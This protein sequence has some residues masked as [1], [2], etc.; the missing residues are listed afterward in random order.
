MLIIKKTNSTPSVKL[1]IEECI[2][3]IK[4]LSFSNDV[5]SFYTPIIEWVEKEFPKLECELKC[6]FN[7]SVF[8]SVTYKYILN[9]MT[10]IL[11]Y[12]QEGKNIK[13]VWYYDVDD[14]D[15][16][17]SAE[18]IAELFNIPFELIKND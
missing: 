1:S 18:D 4:G 11:H 17:E 6:K 2:F 9:I 10:K 7:L 15:N 16:R 13:V 3:E 12:N 5:E 8:N 14:E